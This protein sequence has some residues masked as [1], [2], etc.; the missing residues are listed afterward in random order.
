MERMTFFFLF[1]IL[2][3]PVSD[4]LKR[5]KGNA[6]SKIDKSHFISISPSETAKTQVFYVLPP[7]FVTNPIDQVGVL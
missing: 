4:E 2:I 3:L 7:F 5:G 1:L 6:K